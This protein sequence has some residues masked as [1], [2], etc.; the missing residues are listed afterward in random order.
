VLLTRLAAEA[1]SDV[2]RRD[3]RR[4]VALEELV[5]VGSNFAATKELVARL[6]SAGLV[7]TSRSAPV[8]VS[9]MIGAAAASNTPTLTGLPEPY[10]G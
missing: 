5:L 2:E 10:P 9:P 6:A 8:I 1:A 3:T 7:V 4:R